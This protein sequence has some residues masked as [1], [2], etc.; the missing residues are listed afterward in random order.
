MK[1]TRAV[2]LFVS[3]TL[4]V[5]CSKAESQQPNAPVTEGDAVELV[6]LDVGQGD[7]ILIRSPEG[8]VALIDAGRSGV[9]EQL[10]SHGVDSIDLAV[11]THAHADHIGGMEDVIRSYPVR[12]YMDNGLPHTTATYQGLMRSLQASDVIYLEASARTIEL[13]SVQIRVLKPP[14]CG[15]DQNNCSV[16]LV[17]QFGEFKALLT[18]DSEVEEINHFLQVGVPDVVVLKAA[19]H[20]SR[21]GV[22]PAWLSATKPEVVVISCGLDN[23]YGHPD[24]WALQY[25]EATADKVYRTDWNGE[26]T[27]RGFSDGDYTVSSAQGTIH[28]VRSSARAMPLQNASVT[29]GAADVH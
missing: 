25:Y 6:F 1:Y 17:V 24:A 19:H 22:T 20:G 15:A 14:A 29:T 2:L 5:A 27:V 21:N 13:G 7:A 11:A 18:G 10:R 16:G 26:V 28:G 23:Q 9:E 12:Y 4:A 3:L 8:K